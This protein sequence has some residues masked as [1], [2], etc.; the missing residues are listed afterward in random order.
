[1]ELLLLKYGYAL[2]FAGVMVEGEAVL[3]VAALLARRGVFAWPVVLLV[4]VAANTLADLTYFAL[5]RRRG[6]GWLQARYGD[7]PRFQKLLDLVGR[8]GPLLLL[9]SRFAYGL[10]IAIPAAC[11]ALGMG[12]VAFL[13]TDLAAGFLWAAALV[14]IGYSVGGAFEPLLSKVQGYEMAVAAAILAA[15][16]GG[17]AVLGARHLRDLARKGRLGAADLHRLVPLIIGF[18]GALNVSTAVWPRSAAHVAALEA[19]LPLAVM[20]RS[21]PLVL[22]S[23]LALLHVA[24]SLS[25]R[26]ALAHRV[27]ALALG[28][29]FLS[30]LGHGLSIHHSMVAGL[31]LGYLWIYRRRFQARADPQSARQALIMA[32]VLGALVLVYGF[33]GLRNLEPQ[34]HW[35]A[36]NAPL[37]ESARSGLLLADAEVEPRTPLAARF[38]GSLEIAGWL[39]RA[40]LLVMLLRPV[41]ARTRLEAPAEAVDRAFR[42]WAR[43]S[44]ATFAV[45]G[46]KH[47]LLV[48]GGRGLVAY[49]VR[50]GV[51][52]A[53]GDPLASR[54]EFPESVHAY[55]AHCRS[56]GWIPCVYEAS[57]EALPVYRAQG[58]RTLKMAEE[59][60]IDLP[61]FSLAGGK[62]AALRAMVNKV[63]KRGLTVAS[64]D[65]AAGPDPGIDGELEEVSREWLLGKKQGEMGFTVTR[66]SREGLD[67]VRVFLCRE[68]GRVVAFC[69]WRPYRGDRAVVLDLMRKRQDAPSGAMDLLLAR[70]LEH[71]RDE[72]LEEASLANAPLAN[73]NSPAG[74]LERFTALLF[75]NMNGLYG[76]KSLFQFKKKFAPRWEG[77]YL[78]YP[79]RIDLP[80]VAF[81]MAS[82]HGALGLRHLLSGR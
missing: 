59:A 8:R 52:L 11:G 72:G 49:A 20:Q 6:R 77:R 78:V 42:D 79:G 69:S 14:A 54:E 34:F 80:R 24:R 15:I 41:I 45:E 47:H 25:R 38:L 27:A 57:E 37:I 29:S 22:F 9:A 32:P 67:G 35:S 31:L 17:A 71:L 33:V 26:K 48:A 58:L 64:Y 50:G 19:W 13:A 76:Y 51:A 62:R 23:G 55:I 4:A 2:L 53:A 1:M 5:A 56:N 82:V 75:E 81:A 70:S 7:Q 44:L 30:H 36:G 3:L 39:A 16:A 63:T 28:V 61:S 18:V 73:V 46:D 21:R 43:C 40:Y 66:F 60:V 65:R 12:A 68:G 74:L 10:R